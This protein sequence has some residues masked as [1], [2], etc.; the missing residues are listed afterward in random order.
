[1]LLE[2]VDL[3][4]IQ[5]ISMEFCMALVCSMTTLKL[6]NGHRFVTVTT[7]W[8]YKLNFIQG[9]QTIAQTLIHCATVYPWKLSTGQETVFVPMTNFHWQFFFKSF[10]GF[11]QNPKQKI[12]IQNKKEFLLKPEISSWKCPFWL[13]EKKKGIFLQKI[14]EY[15]ILTGS[16]KN[17]LLC[18]FH[19]C[20][21][22]A[23]GYMVSAWQS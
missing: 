18:S 7:C 20:M 2:Q 4:C 22:L 14:F 23:A 17:I 9:S 21:R 6:L 15:N 5:T 10:W 12:L 1:M 13:K 19:R 8:V 3:S 16:S 11:N